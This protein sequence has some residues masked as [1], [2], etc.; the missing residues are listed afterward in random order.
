MGT[1]TNVAIESVLAQTYPIAEI[2][3]VNAD[4]IDGTNAGIALHSAKSCYIKR[5]LVSK[6]DKT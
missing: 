6:T 1:L 2:I 4:S 5:K 3:I